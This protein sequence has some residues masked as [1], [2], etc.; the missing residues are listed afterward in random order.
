MKDMYQKVKAKIKSENEDV[1]VKTIKN[2]KRKF[3]PY[4]D[5]NKAERKERVLYLWS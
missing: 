4:K 2:K 5:M 1:F 3:K